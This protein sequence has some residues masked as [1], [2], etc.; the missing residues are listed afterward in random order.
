M[1]L[2]ED[3]D[4]TPYEMTL[5]QTVTMADGFTAVTRV[6]GGWVYRFYNPYDNNGNE[7]Y[8]ESSVFVPFNNEFQRRTV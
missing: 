3:V 1:I 5:G 4:Q 2:N 7:A 6:P 8:R